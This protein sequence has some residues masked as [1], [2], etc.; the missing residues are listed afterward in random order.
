MFYGTSI[1]S[2]LKLNPV[3]AYTYIK[4]T[5]CYLIFCMEAFKQAKNHLTHVGMVLMIAI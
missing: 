4:Y 1:L 3:N 5:S 2:Y